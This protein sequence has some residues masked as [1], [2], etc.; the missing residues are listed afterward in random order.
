MKLGS[1]ALF[2]TIMSAPVL[3]G[4][5][6][7][8]PLSDGD[9]THYFT[10]RDGIPARANAS[11]EGDY[12]ITHIFLQQS[13][14][15]AAGSVSEEIAVK[16]L[17]A[18]VARF[19]GTACLDIGA[20]YVVSESVKFA[21]YFDG[22]E[23]G[24]KQSYRGHAAAPSGDCRKW[25]PQKGPEEAATTPSAGQSDW[26]AQSATGSR[27]QQDTDWLGQATNQQGSDW[28]AQAS[29][30]QG[31]DWLANSAARERARLARIERERRVRLRREQEE[32][33]RRLEE[34]RAEERRVALA[35]ADER[36]R[37]EQASRNRAWNNV[38]HALR[39]E[40]DRLR[41]ATV[42]PR[43]PS[44]SQPRTTSRSYAGQSSSSGRSASSGT[45]QFEG[46]SCMRR[47]DGSLYHPE[48]AQYCAS[49][50]TQSRSQGSTNSSGSSSPCARRGCVT[51]EP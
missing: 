10:T 15:T 5:W 49:R 41:Q 8:P 45:T 9:T 7:L 30:R 33:Q 24:Q 19:I 4:D 13:I 20:G 40:I 36:R 34:R 27:T 35:R 44:R 39:G 17:R 1:L 14:P 43:A 28:L 51:I 23:P 12:I 37:E 25:K 46:R 31:G 26:L 11:R 21:T 42:Q 29:E 6:P 22:A 2:L 50:G 3:A 38:G 47:R 32:R 48:N 16:A 18:R